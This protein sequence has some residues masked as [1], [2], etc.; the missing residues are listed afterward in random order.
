MH[1]SIF[2]MN[3]KKALGCS[4][5]HGLEWVWLE[6]PVPTKF[7]QPHY[8]SN[9]AHITFREPEL[10]HN[11]GKFSVLMR[12]SSNYLS[13]FANNLLILHPICHMQDF[14]VFLLTY[15]N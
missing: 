9:I 14:F 4:Y 10:S 12:F 11:R 5:V 7:L 1:H 15:I 2:L 13:W 6:V 8:R 3:L